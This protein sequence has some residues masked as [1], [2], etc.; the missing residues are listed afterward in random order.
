M[1]LAYFS[2]SLLVFIPETWAKDGTYT[3]D[4]WPADAFLLTAEQTAEYWKVTAQAGKELG[5]V[6]GVPAWVDI[7][8]LSTEA[9]IAL[10]EQNRAQ[11]RAAADSE[12]EWRQDAVTEGIATEKETT[13]LAEWKKYRVL[14][15][16]VDTA[17]PIWPTRPEV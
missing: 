8:P 3:K 17:A 16:R 7:P 12:I 13:E 4:N 1:E 15:M 5:V 11:L 9:M 14:L 10:S 2:P 6:E